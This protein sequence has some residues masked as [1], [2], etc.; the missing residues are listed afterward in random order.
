MAPFETAILSDLVAESN[1]IEGYAWTSEQVK[2]TAVAYRELLASP[3]HHFMEALRSDSRVIEAL[4]LYRAHLLAEEWAREQHR[5]VEYEIRGLHSLITGG[6]PYAGRYKETSNRIGGTLHKPSEPWDVSRAMQELVE[7]WQV[8]APDPILDATIVHAW[9]TH[10]HPFEDGNGRMARVLAN[11][12]LVQYEYP[13]LVVRSTTDRGQ[14]Y[15]AL[16]HSD[17]GDILPLWDLFSQILRRTVRTM[18]RAD[19]VRDVI[20][21]RLLVG[22]RQRHHMWMSL[23]ESFSKALRSQLRRKGWDLLVQGYPDI[24]AF[25][26]LTSRDPEG[27]SW[28]LKVLDPSGKPVW[29]LWHGY[30]SDVFVEALKRDP[31]FPSVFFSYRVDDPTSVH[32]YKTAF[33]GGPSRIPNELVFVPGEAPPAFLRWNRELTELDI[34]HVAEEVANALTG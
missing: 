5:P 30:A 19:Y 1:Q 6:E 34:S 15:D 13:P 32:P 10:I 4:G 25:A 14:Y 22:T 27:N 3:V 17:D 11:L 9:L 18:S 7:W 8:G 16:A 28:Y 21:D 24:T 12:A 20:N 31:G 26:L 29:L 23:A 33:L 2:A